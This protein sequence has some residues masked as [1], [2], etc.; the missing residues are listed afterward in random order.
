LIS[1]IFNEL[2]REKDYRD[3]DKQERLSRKIEHRKGIGEE[4]RRIVFQKVVLM[5]KWSRN[6]GNDKIKIHSPTKVWL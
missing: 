6:I 5:L 3:N 1:G 2:I 4:C